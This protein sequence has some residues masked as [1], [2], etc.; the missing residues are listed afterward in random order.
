V[1]RFYNVVYGVASTIR[2]IQRPRHLDE[3]TMTTFLCSNS[4]PTRCLVIAAVIFVFGGCSTRTEHAST[5]R[6]KEIVL[7]FYKLGLQDLKPQEAFARYMTPDFREHAADSAGGTIQSNIAFLSGLMKQS[8]APTFEIVRTIAE[9]DLV[10]L[11]VKVTIGGGPPVALGEIFRVQDDRI[12]EHWDLVQP[13]R[14]HP[15]NP[16]SVF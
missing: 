9:G 6:S 5:Q 12:A 3:V 1:T 2:A 8:P 7:A 11:H 13:P 16:N 15:I 14:D 4:T 10:F